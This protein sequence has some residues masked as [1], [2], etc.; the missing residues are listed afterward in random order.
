MVSDRVCLRMWR[1]R[2]V[3]ACCLS[4]LLWASPAA[5]ARADD[6]LPPIEGDPIMVV[7]V[8]GVERLLDDVDYLFGSADRS[9]LTEIVNG[10]LGGVNDLKGLERGKPLGALVYLQP[11]LV[12]QPGPVVFLPVSDIAALSRTVEVGPVVVKKRSEDRYEIIGQRRT[13]YAV[14]RHGFAFVANS[15]DLLDR[16]FYDPADVHQALSARYDVAVQITP[17]NIPPGMRELF[18]GVLRTNAQ[19]ELQ[20]RDD[21]AEAAYAVRRAQGKANLK[22]VE[23]LLT[24]TESVTLG[25]DA[26]RESRKAVAELTLEATPDSPHAEVLR[27]MA[28]E[29]S[30]FSAL[31][32][33]PVPLSI[34]I[35]TMLDADGKQTME[36]LFKL[37]QTETGKALTQ[38]DAGELGTPAGGQGVID[39][40]GAVVV[41]SASEQL[42][43]RL[44]EPLK[45][46]AAA[47]HLDLFAQFRGDQQQKFVLLGGV[48][49]NGAAGME[50]AFREIVERVLEKAPQ[51][52]PFDVAWGAAE[53]GDITLH[54]F[55]GT[56]IREQEQRLYGSE[57]ALYVGFGRETVWLAVGGDQAVP[58]LAAAI[59]RARETVTPE[60]ASVSAPFRLVVTANTW[61]GINP[62]DPNND[63]AKAAFQPGD[64]SLRIDV[65]PTEKGVRLRV[66]LEEGF[67]R[68]LGLGVAQR[69]DESQ[70]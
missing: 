43:Q 42:A 12:P 21:E 8:A 4:G 13:L 31:L 27:E 49:V 48:G 57:F 15:E 51:R 44:F 3:L 68:L 36:E 22:F 70:N 14:M 64:D 1:L 25:I 19:T 59:E 5:S 54:R 67:I 17:G 30:H 6:E 63:L 39:G 28:A 33:D 16:A 29:P 65:R 62:N 66:E 18:L 52:P 56:Q 60:R 38:L 9:D 37:G 58:E 40:Q 46:T 23:R 45:E 20:R 34:S 24:E 41:D 26:S 10:L 47:G 7:N 69:Y 35:S 55:T 11:G 61:I 50:S 32:A 2:A 53:A